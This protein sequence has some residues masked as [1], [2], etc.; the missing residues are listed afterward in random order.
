MYLADLIEVG[1]AADVFSPPHHP[2]TEALFSSIPRLDF[3][4][5]KDRVPLRGTMP[6]LTDP[7]SGCRFHTRCH[8]ILG[9]ICVSEIPPDQDAGNGHTY[10]CHIPPDELRALQQAG[11]PQGDDAPV[12]TG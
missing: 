11:A 12:A 9:D 8:R 10:K 3:E 5:Q 1:A 6:S 4:E 2:Y 7:P